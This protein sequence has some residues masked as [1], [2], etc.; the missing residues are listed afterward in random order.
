[1]AISKGTW[2]GSQALSTTFA[3]VQLT[4][5]GPATGGLV[6]LGGLWAF[7][8]T[9]AGGATALTVRVTRDAAGDECI[10]PDF[11]VD[12][13]TGKTTATDGTVVVDYNRIPFFGAA[14]MHLSIKTD[15]GTA[16]M[17]EAALTFTSN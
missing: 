6:G 10:C 4:L 12:L 15:V 11:E 2:S 14:A 17:T 5:S 13:T 9:I 8:T 7:V 3:T 1:M 16:V